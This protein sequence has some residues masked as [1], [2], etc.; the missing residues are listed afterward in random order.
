MMPFGAVDGN[1]VHLYRLANGQGA[2]AEVTDY[3]A[4]LVS[5]SVP[6]RLGRMGDVVLGF[7]S[8]AEYAE[9]SP[10]FGCVVGRFANR[11]ARGEFTLDGNRYRLAITNG[12]NHLHGGSVGFNKRIWNAEAIGGPDPSLKMTYVSPDG[13]EGYPGTLTTEVTYTLTADN[14]LRLDYLAVTDKPTVVNLTNHSYFNLAGEDGGATRVREQVL[15][16]RAE[17]YVPIDETSIPLGRLDSVAGTPFDFRE[18]TAI[19]RHLDDDNPQLHNG[20]GYDHNYVLKTGRDA[21]LIHAA[22][23]YDPVSG[24][25]VDVQTTEPGVQFYT[26]NNL[27]G[28]RGKNGAVYSPRS[29]FCLET[30]NFPDSPNQRGFPS[31][32]LRPEE[33]YLQ[34]TIYAFRTD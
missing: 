27:N 22:T 15:T 6:D 5:L 18:P 9:N 25:V 12:P 13:E 10:F 20:N 4:I 28:E 7:D 17:R 33:R 32:V 34:T 24:R 16:I 8:A 30:Q 1:R 3:G 23:A 11:I 26:A 31:P 21:R 29:A 2:S 19:G 14:A